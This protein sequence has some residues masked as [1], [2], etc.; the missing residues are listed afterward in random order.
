MV[1]LSRSHTRRGGRRA[2]DPA[3]IRTGTCDNYIC[4]MV[5]DDRRYRPRTLDD[6]EPPSLI[7]QPP[8]REGA[9]SHPRWWSERAPRPVLADALAA[10]EALLDRLER[11][12]HIAEGDR[13]QAQATIRE[14]YLRSQDMVRVLRDCLDL[15][16]LE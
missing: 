9:I 10:S 6:D 7:N 15:S 13:V 4:W 12:V 5:D 3:G 16:E 11:G 8:T 2:N 1:P 14:L